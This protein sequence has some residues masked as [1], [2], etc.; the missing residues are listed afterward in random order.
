MLKDLD[1]GVIL[2]G[3]LDLR[4]VFVYESITS[5]NDTLKEM[6]RS[7]AEDRTLIVADR[8]TGGKGR[9]GRSFSS[10]ADTGLYMSLYLKTPSAMAALEMTIASAC[11]VCAAIGELTDHA[12]VIKWV[13]DVY[14]EG[15][16]VC[17]ILCEKAGEG[18][19][20]G[21][22]INV[23]TPRDGF[24][25]AIRNTAIA[26]DRDISRDVLCAAV[27]RHLITFAEDHAAAMS[28]YRQKM[29]LI[30]KTVVYQGEPLLV[31]GVDD[32]GALLV[33]DGDGIERR[34]FTGEVSLHGAA[35]L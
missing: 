22:G 7:G 6:A 12:P 32:D 34:L 24:P 14:L 31:I 5:T 19:V 2:N 17:G 29:F 15:K 4:N 27:A 18:V 35:V 11:A 16:K 21:I 26:I 1:S 28:Y 25:E 3:C 9:L 23:R 13:N 10:P 33:R 8:Q 20:I 30:G